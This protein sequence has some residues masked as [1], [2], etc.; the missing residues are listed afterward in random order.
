MK[1]MNK[2][3][4]R[5]TVIL[6]FALSLLFLG[7]LNLA[8]QGTPSVTVTYPNGGE[9]LIP[10][11]KV[12]ITWTIQGDINHAAI[13]HR[14][15]D[16]VPETYK[17]DNA[18]WDFHPVSGNQF[19]WD[20]PRQNSSTAKLWIEA[21][22]ALD[23]RL[24]IDASNNFFTI[25]DTCGVDEQ[26][27]PTAPQIT[28]VKIGD[29]V[30]QPTETIEVEKGTNLTLVGTA[31]V[32]EVVT[33]YVKTTEKKFTVTADT[34][35][36]WTF[37]IFTKNLAEGPHQ[38]DLETA[39]S[40]RAKALTFI[41]LAIGQAPSVS[42]PSGSTTAGTDRNGTIQRVDGSLPYVELGASLA[43]ALLAGTLT[44]F[45]VRRRVQRV[46]QNSVEPPQ[47]T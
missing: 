40:P 47:I 38:V 4:M 9:C 7:A 25:S 18:A 28:Q 46:D 23:N 12:Y 35:G 5:G 30:F 33:V 43:A 21:H 2:R 44:Y 6:G 20:V 29:R 11:S 16:Q 22:D 39:T 36:K 19:L 26:P 31:P 3:W 1:E 41:V 15:D 32:N 34:E 17:Q 10:G 14:F 45:M 42:A 37:E 13:G 27:A 24:A 8:A